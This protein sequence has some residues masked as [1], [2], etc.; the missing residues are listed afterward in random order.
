MTVQPQSPEEYIESQPPERRDALRAVRET[1]NRNLPPGYEEGMQYGMI[2]WY[3]PLERFPDT[4]NGRPLGVAAL[5]SQKNYMS[6][7]LNSVYGDPGTER[8]FKQRYAQTGKRLDMGKSCVRFRR[9]ED[10]PLEVI[11][12]TIARA[13]LD[14]FVD[15]YRAARGSSRI[16]R[17]GRRS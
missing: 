6:L 5:A 7:Y 3:V 4:Y 8:W 10:L 2:G 15:R 11:G 1:I 9:L 12:E 13:D 14:G 16:P 17:A